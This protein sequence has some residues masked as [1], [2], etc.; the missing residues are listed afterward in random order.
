MK[1]LSRLKL[2][3]SFHEPI[4]QDKRKKRVDSLAFCLLSS[5]TR[6]GGKREKGKCPGRGGIGQKTCAWIQMGLKEVTLLI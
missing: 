5:L 2:S 3:K 4:Q 6:R 1:W